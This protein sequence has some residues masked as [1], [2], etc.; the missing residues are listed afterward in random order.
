[1]LRIGISA[2]FFHADPKR[3]IFKGKTLLYIEQS[4]AHWI[5]SQN[6]IPFMIPT[7]DPESGIHLRDVMDHIDGLILHGGSDVAPESYG[8]KPLK[9]EWTGDA[10]RD[11]Y[12]IELL[13]EAMA[14]NRPVLGLCRGAQLMNVA[15]GGTLIQDIPSQIPG[16]LVHRNWD[17]YD[18]NFHQIQFE[19]GSNL[20][21]IYS[22]ISSGK[23]NSVHH[24][25][26]QTLG[27]DLVVEAW[28]E[29]D[30]VIEAI[31]LDSDQYVRAVQWH[32]EFHSPEDS[33][34]LDSSRL[35]QDFLDQ[36]RMR[37]EEKN[38]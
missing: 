33:S 35:L 5:Q 21:N 12:E 20:A 15:F 9:S 29:K 11:V 27:K 13:K 31:R 18:Q 4:V 23:V 30:R 36:V 37:K 6:A 3:P 38:A 24:Q 1:M 19:P 34:L 25:A 14:K 28:S 22:G 16:A 17:I 7:I 2:C 26:I 32:P 8:E 10:I